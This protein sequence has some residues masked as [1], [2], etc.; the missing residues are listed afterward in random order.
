MGENPVLGDPNM[1]HTLKGFK[2]LEFLLVRTS[3]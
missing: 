2:N 3:F 1:G